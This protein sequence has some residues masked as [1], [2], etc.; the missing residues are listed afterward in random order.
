MMCAIKK[1]FK[2]DL[3]MY[4]DLYIGWL[5]NSFVIGNL[6]VHRTRFTSKACNFSVAY[7]FIQALN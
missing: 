6:F 3:D 2:D 4:Y 5:N 1:N 7:L